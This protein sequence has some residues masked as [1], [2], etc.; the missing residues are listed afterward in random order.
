MQHP[1]FAK[2]FSYFSKDQSSL[3]TTIAYNFLNTR[4]VFGES[5]SFFYWL[6]EFGEIPISIIGFIPLQYGY[7]IQHSTFPL[8]QWIQYDTQ[9]SMQSVMEY[10]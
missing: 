5:E 7:D 1:E 9:H 2:P 10:Y 4:S 6:R 8:F 3:S